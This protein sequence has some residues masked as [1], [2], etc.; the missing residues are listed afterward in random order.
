MSQDNPNSQSPGKGEPQRRSRRQNQPRKPVQPVWKAQI[1]RFLRSTIG[2]L[3]GVVVKLEESP[4]GAGETP[5]FVT[6]IQQVWGTTLGTIR[7]FLPRNLSAQLSDTAL[8]GV[9]AGIVVVLVFASSTLFGNKPPEVATAPP[10]VEETAPPITEA[11]PEVSSEITT[12]PVEEEPELSE[13]Q[14]KES[15]VKEPEPSPPVE[16]TPEPE[17]EPEPEPEP[18]PTPTPIPEP[19]ILTPEQNLIA[20]IQNQ[21]AEVSDRFAEGLIKS[22]KA[23]F[24]SS[25][26]AI[27]LSD[28]WYNLKTSQQDKLAAQMLQRSQ[29]LDFFYLEITDS[30]GKLIARSPVVG[31]EMIIFKRRLPEQPAQG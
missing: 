26:L 4:D 18:E 14:E 29:E 11:T 5:G 8:T 30:K 6:K 7:S 23:N 21:V 16:A 20:S 3:E 24:A 10:V 22:T 27:K 25:S 12:P 13:P 17:T 9:L 15:E 31:N 2:V 1:I 19:V 28:E